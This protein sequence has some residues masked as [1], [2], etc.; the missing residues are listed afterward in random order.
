MSVNTLWIIFLAIIFTRMMDILEVGFLFLM[1]ALGIIWFD[2][3]WYDSFHE[4]Y[5][6]TDEKLKEK[7]RKKKEKQIQI[8]EEA[9]TLLIIGEDDGE[10][11]TL[12]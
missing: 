10:Q 1:R 7:E 11:Q 4:W 3:D 2:Y 12:S 6:K 8:E 9:N 5:R